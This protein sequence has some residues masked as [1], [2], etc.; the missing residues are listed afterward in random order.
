M[1]HPCWRLTEK[2]GKRLGRWLDWSN[3]GSVDRIATVAEARSKARMKGFAAV[4][5]TKERR[6]EIPGKDRNSM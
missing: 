6:T 2:I 3:W 1:K 5:V 4:V